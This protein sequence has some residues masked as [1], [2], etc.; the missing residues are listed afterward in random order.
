MYSYCIFI[1]TINL[2]EIKNYKNEEEITNL[3]IL[4]PFFATLLQIYD[5]RKS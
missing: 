5:K 2:Y 1:R 4:L 3:I